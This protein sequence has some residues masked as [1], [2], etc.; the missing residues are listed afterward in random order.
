VVVGEAGVVGVLEQLDLLSFLVDTTR[1]RIH[2]NELRRIRSQ[3]W[4]VVNRSLFRADTG[5]HK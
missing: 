2:Y 1:T 3:A 4:N 5:S